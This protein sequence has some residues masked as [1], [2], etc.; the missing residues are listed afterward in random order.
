MC[1]LIEIEGT[2]KSGK[3]TQSKKICEWLNSEGYKCK[4]ISFPQYDDDSSQY[5]KKYLLGGLGDIDSVNPYQAGMLFALDR[6]MT[7]IKSM[8]SDMDEYDFIILDRYVG[9][10]LIHQG[11][12]KMSHIT[13][14]RE[15]TDYWT[16]FEY[17]KL[18][19][20]R[21]DITLILLTSPE[22][23]E[24]IAKGRHNKINDSEEE[25]IHEANREYEERCYETASALSYL[26]NWNPIY[27]D[28][29]RYT[30]ENPFIRT[31]DDIFDA[32]K[33]TL[34]YNRIVW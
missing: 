13:D 22:A 29:Y 31:I 25:D 5:V 28:N 9:S 30:N 17:N 6:Y 1:K 7:Y 16:D 3:E 8:K 15:F 12:K 27:T 19:L 26:L 32:I 34:E 23:S 33:L 24:I 21:P 4:V 11:A 10:N 14:L 2:D 20:P 18:E